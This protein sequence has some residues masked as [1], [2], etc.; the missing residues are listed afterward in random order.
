MLTLSDNA[1]AHFRRLIEQ[2][3]LDDVGVRIQAVNG[4]TPK[5]DCQLEFCG[6][7]E[8][9]GD[10]WALQCDGFVFYVDAASIGYFDQAEIDYQMN[11]TGGQLSVR[12]PKLKGVPPA[13]GASLAERIRYIIET[14]IN[15][16]I[17]S[18]GGRVSLEEI[19]D[20]GIVV[21]RFGGGCHGCGMADVTL[22]QGIEKTLRARLPEITEVRDATDHASGHNP[23]YRGLQGSS[24]VR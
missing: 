4:G 6:A 20:D 3:G 19:A 22:K 5:A 16:Q 8:L 9:I 14:E 21:L 11:S 18:H 17:A 15:P 23:Y 12:A 24:A 2:Q 1:Q 7:D 10:E 13:E